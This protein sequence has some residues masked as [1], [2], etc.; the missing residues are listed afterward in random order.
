MSHDFFETQRKSPDPLSLIEG[1]GLGTR[2]G[3]G[4]NARWIPFPSGCVSTFAH[5]HYLRDYRSLPTSLLSA[6]F[7]GVL[8]TSDLL[9]ANTCIKVELFIL[10]G[11]QFYL[12][13]GVAVG[14]VKR[15][16]TGVA[17]GVV[18]VIL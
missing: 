17:L 5:A 18:T 2:L 8:K 3:S 4:Q 9:L 15:L 7:L 1:R 11:E 14:R 16:L 6:V 13:S 12:L 10:H